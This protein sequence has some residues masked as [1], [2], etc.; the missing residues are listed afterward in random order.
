M[1]NPFIELF[2]TIIT[3]YNYVVM[4]WVALSLLIN[5]EIVNRFNPIVRKIQYTLDRLVE[6]A[7]RPIRKLMDRILP[8]LG[9]IDLSPIVLFLLLRFAQ[10]ALYSWFYNI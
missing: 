8:N 5:F 1:L 2:S 3:L 7:L 4:G 10:N 9:G 6:P